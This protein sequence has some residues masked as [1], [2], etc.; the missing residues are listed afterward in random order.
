MKKKTPLLLLS[1]MA[2]SCASSSSLSLLNKKEAGS[3]FGLESEYSFNSTFKVPTLVK[4]GVTYSSV[5]EFPSGATYSLEE[6][7]LSESGIYVIHYSAEKDGIFYSEDHSFLVRCPYI[8]FSGTKSYASYEQSERTYGKLGLYVSLAEGETL[9]FNNPANISDGGTIFEGFVAPSSVGS[10]DFSE[11]YI[12]MNEKGGDGNVV[13]VR[14]KATNEGLNYP[15]TYWSGKANDQPYV[16]YEANFDSIHTNDDFGCPVTHSF[17]GY[18]GGQSY[19][20]DAKCGDYTLQLNY[21]AEEKAIYAGDLLITDFDDSTFYDTLWDGFSSDEVSLSIS[22]KAYSSTS[23][24][25]VI[26]SALGQDLTQETI[27]DYDAPILSVD[28]PETLPIAKKGCSYPV[29]SASAHDA[30]DGNTDVSVH[31]YYDVGSGDYLSLPIT[32]GRFETAREGDYFLV[33]EAQDKSGNLAQ[34]TIRIATGEL[35]ALSI[36]PKGEVSKSVKIGEEY[37]LPEMEA[38]GGSGEKAIS[39]Y[40]S[41]GDFLEN[42]ASTFVPEELGTYKIVAEVKDALN[43]VAT[44]EY[45]LE[46]TSNEEAMIYEDIATP[47]YYIA[48]ALY[49]LPK[50]VCYDYSS[51]K[52]EEVLM[53]VSIDN[54]VYPYSLKSGDLFVPKITKAQ[55][56]ITFTF[57]YKNLSIEKRVLVINPYV[58]GSDGLE[59]FYI[60]NYLRVDNA[61]V[62]SLD[63]ELDIL[64]NSK[65]DV[66]AE[67]ANPIIAENATTIFSTLPSKGELQNFEVTFTDSLNESESVT[68]KIESKAMGGNVYYSLNSR[69]YATKTSLAKQ[70]SLQ[71]SYSSGVFTFNQTGVK[72]NAYDDGKPFAGFSSGKVYISVRARNVASGSGFAWTRIDNQSLSYSSS[73]YNAPRI[74]IIGNYGGSRSIGSKATINRVVAGDVLDPNANSYVSVT[75][76]SGEIAKDVNG[77][78][79]NSVSASQEYEINLSEYGQYIVTYKATDTSGNTASFIYA[80]NVEDE[81]APVITLSSEPASE[82]TLGEYIRLPEIKAA[83]NSGKEVIVTVYM[84]TPDGQRVLIDGNHNSFKPS[85]AGVYTLRIRAMDES[86]NIAYLSRTITVK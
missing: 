34:K 15:W 47:K 5:L 57:S 60:E 26:L 17:Y 22:A 54:G 18:Y 43:Q 51:G 75:A 37:A 61:S 42:P 64:A 28:A 46:V 32:D 48:D 27:Y 77:V 55:K 25:F 86:G 70:N 40:V 3:E 35:E 69:S 85:S 39:Y 44:Y 73:D 58:V 49:N 9:T 2:V 4:E 83:D 10:M 45:D 20:G 79:L 65:G 72:A 7:T 6:V 38:K 76:P 63:T 11:L 68:M 14:A 53:D 24:N 8:Q 29:F 78:P 80:I 19:L 31:A 59:R 67:F 81:E 82:I 71:F 16:G 74:A 21:N 41:K 12:T 62:Q 1:L 84:E 56:E 13:T 66:A 52:K 23:A 50:A 36:A 30:I 33:Y